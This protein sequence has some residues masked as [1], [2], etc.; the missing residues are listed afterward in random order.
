MHA[1][2]VRQRSMENPSAPDSSYGC[3]LQ[4]LP[5]SCY[6]PVTGCDLSKCCLCSLGTRQSWSLWLTARSC[7]VALAYCKRSVFRS[8]PPCW[9]TRK[10]LDSS[11]TGLKLRR[12]LAVLE[13]VGHGRLAFLEE[14]VQGHM[15][16]H[17]RICC[18]VRRQMFEHILNIVLS[19]Q[20]TP[21]HNTPKNA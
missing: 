18:E 5:Y 12:R 13:R 1:G 9:C 14:C 19:A 21:T 2:H 7:L 3:W 11:Q 17:L 6:P 4:K 16:R 10:L 20:D 15:P 8:R